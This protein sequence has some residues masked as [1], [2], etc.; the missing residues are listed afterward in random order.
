MPKKKETVIEPET[1]KKRRKVLLA[2]SDTEVATISKKEGEI[3]TPRGVDADVEDITKNLGDT[4][5]LAYEIFHLSQSV[6]R[7]C[8]RFDRGIKAAG[9]KARR[10]VQIMRKLSAELR[11]VISQKKKEIEKD[12]QKVAFAKSRMH[13]L[14]EYREKKKME[15]AQQA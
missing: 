11:K 7:N 1:G 6:L 14:A 9:T 2:K 15:K 3:I 4:G 8:D 12:P 5:K 10:S 13:K